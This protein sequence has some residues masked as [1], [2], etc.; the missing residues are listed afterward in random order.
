MKAVEALQAGNTFYMTNN[1][2]YAVELE[3]GHST[4]APTGI[5]RKVL[6][7]YNEAITK[8]QSKARR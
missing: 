5:V 6:L 8:A 7:S 4:Q 2:P 1:L 3:F